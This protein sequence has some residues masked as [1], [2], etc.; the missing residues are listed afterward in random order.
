MSALEGS[1]A[2]NVGARLT[3]TGVNRQGAEWQTDLQL[4]TDPQLISEF[5]QPFS[6]GSRWF[7][8]PRVNLEQWNLNAYIDSDAIARYRISESEFGIDT[9]M[10][11]GSV[12][13]IRVGAYRGAGRASVKIGDPTLSSEKFDTGGVLT[14]LRYDTRDDAQF[15]RSGV[16]ADVVW[17]L[18]LPDLGADERFDTVETEV[19]GTWSRGKNSWNVGALYATTLQS[20]GAI[21]DLFRLGGFLRLSGLDRGQ[22]SGPHA[23]MLRLVY[24][25]RVSESTGGIFDVPIY[26]GGSLELGNTWQSRSDISFDSALVNGGLFAGFDTKIGPIYLGAGFAEGGSGNYYLFFGAPPRARGW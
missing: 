6:A 23:A 26:L 3:K 25:R 22:I 11:L 10:L 18:S 19:E 20:Q 24:Y 5:Y 8:A 7:V 12:G 1:S 17:N 14:R 9:G 4:G 2:F 16:R 13:D 15:P 21:Q